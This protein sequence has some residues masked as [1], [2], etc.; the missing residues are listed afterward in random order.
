MGQRRQA[1]KTIAEVGEFSFLARLIPLLRTGRGTVVGPGQDCALVR[2]PGGLLLTVD[3]L[4]EGVHFQREWLSPHQLGRRSYLVNASDIAAMGGTPLF[5]LASLG[6][7]PSYAARDLSQLYMGLARAAREHGAQVVGGNLT[8]AAALFVSVT[9]VAAAPRRVVTRRGAR[10]GDRLY[11]TG[12]LGDAALAWR[13]LGRRRRAA[14]ALVRRFRE[15]SPRLRAG[16]FLVERGIVSAMIDVSDGIVQDLGHICAE[17]GVGARIDT[18]RVPLSTAYRAVM[19]DDVRLALHGGEDYELLC[20]VP[21]PN[22]RS[23]ERA[24]PRLGC[25]ITEIG[26]I[27]ATRRVELVNG[28][29][30]KYVSAVQGYDHFCMRPGAAAPPGRRRSSSVGR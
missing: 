26:E 16:R 10:V 23:L 14:P 17:S 8:R 4:V 9:L 28:N 6:V 7:P 12:T 24:R 29:G 20:A 19:G 13:L 30:T 11:V 25:A 21:P 1:G 15:P 5:L 18:A 27:T 2:G 3:A 22:V